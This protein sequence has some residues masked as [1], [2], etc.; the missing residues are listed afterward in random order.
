MLQVPSIFPHPGSTAFLA[1][2]GQQV[3][4]IQRNADG[5]ALV[6][7]QGQHPADRCA[8]DTFTVDAGT[9]HETYDDAVA[10]PRARSAGGRPRRQRAAH[11]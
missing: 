11:R 3:R 6:G 10:R 4:I 7:R 5:R 1:P 9:L 2:D 8:S